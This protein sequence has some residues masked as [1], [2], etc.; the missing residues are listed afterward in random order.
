VTIHSTAQ[1][2]VLV[3]VVGWFRTGADHVA[4]TPARLVDTRS[5]LGA[6]VGP[7]A[8]DGTITVHS[9]A[10]TNVVVDVQGY[11]KK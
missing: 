6:P 5:G 11:V 7:V 3:D 1:T 8:A 2:D 4:V 10:Q 9:T